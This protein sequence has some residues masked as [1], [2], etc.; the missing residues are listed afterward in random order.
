[1]VASQQLR[2][3]DLIGCEIMVLCRTQPVIES[4]TDLGF[5]CWNF[6]YKGLTEQLQEAELSPFH[7]FWSKIH[8]FTRHKTASWRFIEESK[9]NL[10][11]P[12]FCKQQLPD[13]VAV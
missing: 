8:S 2:C 7:N 12:N 1:M 5:C 9:M 13:E 10:Q 6:G 4:S 11:S 3:R